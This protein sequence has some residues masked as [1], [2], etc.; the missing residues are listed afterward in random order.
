MTLL[1]QA[2]KFI[3]QFEGCKL[4]AYTPLEGLANGYAIGYGFTDR[5]IQSNTVWTQAQCDQALQDK[6]QK[7]IN[8]LESVIFTNLNQNQMTAVIDLCYNLGIG[9]F[10]RTSPSLPELLNQHAFGEFCVHLMK[11]CYAGKDWLQSLQKRR[12]AEKDL[13]LTALNNN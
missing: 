12:Q 3:A 1:E 11:Y 2:C 8:S 4:Q 5:S 10:D 13:F 9:A 7:I 6:V